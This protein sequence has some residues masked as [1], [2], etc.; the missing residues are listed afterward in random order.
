M[1]IKINRIHLEIDYVCRYAGVGEIMT[2][3]NISDAPFGITS[4]D[5]IPV[6]RD[7]ARCCCPFQSS[8]G[9]STLKSNETLAEI[10]N[11]P[12]V[13]MLYKHESVIIKIFNNIDT[14]IYKN[15]FFFW[16]SLLFLQFL[17]I[18]I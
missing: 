17:K 18:Y 3:L 10:N 15:L 4:V 7:V 9:N 13:H 1:G 16:Y 8:T 5:P 11:Y 12:S 6:H 2:S 14:R